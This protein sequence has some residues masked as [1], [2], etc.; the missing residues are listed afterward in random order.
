MSEVP[1]RELRN[2]TSAVL[3]RAEAGEELTVTVSGRAVAQILPLRRRPRSLPWQKVLVHPAD[4]G[5]ASDLRAILD[6]T[7][8]DEDEDPWARAVHR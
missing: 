4:P 7:T 3:H 6:E 2:H 5:L 8:S 1:L